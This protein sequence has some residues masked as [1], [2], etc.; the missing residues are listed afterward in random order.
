MNKTIKKIRLEDLGYSKF[1]KDNQKSTIDNN[2]I[3]ALIIAEHKE[4]YILRNETSEFSAKITGKMMFTA[5][6]REDY[7]AVGDW[8]L[9]IILD[10]KQAIIREILPRKTVLMRK[11]AGKSDT[12][13]IASNIDTAFI[14]Q[15][16][17]RDYNLN[18][19]E[20]YF[21]L[22]ESGNIKTVIV[23]NKTDLISESDLEIKL[24]EIKARFRNTKIYATSTTTGK[25]VADFKKNIKQ[26]VTY[27]FLGSSGVGKSSIIN[28]LVGENLIETGEISSY[29][30]RGKHVTTH[31]E[32]F[33]LENGGLLIDNPGMREIGLLDSGAGI[34]NVFSEIHDLSKKCKFSD[35]TH[36]NEPNCA[37]L[38]AINLGVLDKNKYD[39]YIKLLKENEYNTMTKL[40]KRKKDRDFGQFIKTAKNQ[41]KKYKF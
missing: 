35:C 41:I 37:V 6:S 19:F 34:K 15:S 20:R 11:S 7:P 21:S 27:C 1:F 40:E 23:L 26:G 28:M 2:L 30:K 24:A 36:I 39:N 3:P 12:Q 17:D 9:I 13:I 29:T 8:V 31:R 5:S 25:G 22:A 10:N 18:R 32:L 4:L 38:S 16:P 14:I 33:I